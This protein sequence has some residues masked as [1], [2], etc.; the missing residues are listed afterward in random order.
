MFK[1]ISLSANMDSFHNITFKDGLNVIMG[2]PTHKNIIDKKATTNGIGKSLLIKIIDFCLGAK[3]IRE[4]EEPLKDW[5]FTLE[6]LIDEQSY[7]ISRAVGEQNIIQFNEERIS[8]AKF[9]ERMENL[10]SLAVDFSFRSIISRFLRKGKVAYN[11]YLTFVPKEKPS[12]TLLI[13][14]Y[15]L[16]LDYTLCQKKILLK[17]A[18]DSNQDILSRSQKDPAFRELF[19]ISNNDIE[20]ELSNI[21]FEMERLEDEIR[22]NNYAENYSDIQ[23]KANKISDF[24]DSLNNRKF[25]LENR[26]AIIEEALSRNVTVDLQEVYDLYD[27]VSLH[28]NDKLKRSLF[29]VEEFHKKLYTSRKEMLSKDLLAI[30]NELSSILVQIEKQNKLLDENLAFL[31]SHSAMDKYV[32]TVRQID[33]LMTKKKELMRVSNIEKEIKTKIEQNKKDFAT[34]N[35]DA[36]VYLDSIQRQKDEI[37]KQFVNLAKLFYE[38]KKSALVIKVN[39]G[40]NQ[41]R[42]NIDARI[43]SDGADGIQEIITFCFDWVVLN[44]NI[45][46]QSFI[47]HDSLLLANVERRQKE[48][49]FELISSLCGNEKQY[50]INVNEDQIDGFNDKTKQIVYDNTILVLTDESA[51]SKLLGIEVDLGREIEK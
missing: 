27:S 37:G 3:A 4:W 45:T 7:K 22:Q 30:K 6:I 19:G 35:I 11:N 20:L 5:V 2:K 12:S 28:F 21:E 26:I 39:D 10:L 8:L 13:L 40:D 25:L 9:K 15:L 38:N 31:K 18:M 48:I 17:K 32:A 14:A 29:E 42:F 41:I 51:T 43:T 46:K 49:L 24:L 47:Y 44:Q 36:Q 50:I 34:S 23:E 33:F 16:G 1:L